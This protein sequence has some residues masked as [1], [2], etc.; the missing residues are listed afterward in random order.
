M[1]WKSLTA[2]APQCSRLKPANFMSPSALKELSQIDN[3][4]QDAS[5][6]SGQDSYR[7]ETKDVDLNR[8]SNIFGRALQLAYRV[9]ITESPQPA[10]E[11]IPGSR[12]SRSRLCAAT[13]ESVKCFQVLVFLSVI[14]VARIC[15]LLSAHV[16]DCKSDI[17]FTGQQRADSSESSKR[18][19]GHP[20]R[21]IF[22]LIIAQ[23]MLA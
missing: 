14:S 21:N 15:L 5:G 11:N 1:I 23:R 7:V 22:L 19:T 3:T 16:A 13:V 10:A 2:A 8:V 9:L 20:Q 6:H 17:S 12:K 4:L 18:Q